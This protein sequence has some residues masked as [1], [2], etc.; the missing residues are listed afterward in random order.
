MINEPFT[1]AEFWSIVG[2]DN[3]TKFFTDQKINYLVYRI[4]E[5][6]ASSM[7]FD[8]RPVVKVEIDSVGRPRI[9]QYFKDHATLM[10]RY[11]NW[12]AY[13]DKQIN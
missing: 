5:A 10:S 4:G 3:I 11:P 6:C 9:I 1:P 12:S 13:D 8:N 2:I 7:E